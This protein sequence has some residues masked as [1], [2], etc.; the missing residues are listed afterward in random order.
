MNAADRITV[1][2]LLLQDSEELPDTLEVELRIY[3]ERLEET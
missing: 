3:L 2:R 1:I